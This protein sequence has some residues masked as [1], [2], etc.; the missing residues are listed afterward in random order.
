MVVMT[1]MTIKM[2]MTTMKI[3]MVITTMTITM[4]ISMIIDIIAF[5]IHGVKFSLFLLFLLF[6]LS[7]VA[8]ETGFISGNF[9]GE[10]AINEINKVLSMG[11]S[12][13]KMQSMKTTNMKHHS[14]NVT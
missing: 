3:T 14:S 11:I 12:V 6:L 10:N 2:V 7:N 5:Y 9:C 8:R 13:V 4:V 1:T